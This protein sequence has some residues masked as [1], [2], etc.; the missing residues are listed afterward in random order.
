[1]AFVVIVR[2]RWRLGDAG[3]LT[4]FA[5]L[6]TGAGYAL[7]AALQPHAG[8]Y[9]DQGAIVLAALGFA[10]SS[11]VVA[12][13]RTHQERFASSCCEQ[14]FLPRSLSSAASASR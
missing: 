12:L 11:V 2:S 1:M 13:L 9:G 7:A 8:S 5:A 6:G 4:P 10:L 14:A 3:I